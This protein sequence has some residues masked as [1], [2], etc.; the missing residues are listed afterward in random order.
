MKTFIEW[1]RAM[2]KPSKKDRIAQMKIDMFWSFAGNSNG[3]DNRD[4]A[5][6]FMTAA[7]RAEARMRD[8]T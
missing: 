6:L 5:G 3:T 8:D 7:S 4:I 1:L 2:P